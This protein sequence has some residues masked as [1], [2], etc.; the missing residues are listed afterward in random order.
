MKE[1]DQGASRAVMRAII[2]RSAAVIA[3]LDCLAL[4]DEFE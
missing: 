2:T 1:A 4:L 3:D